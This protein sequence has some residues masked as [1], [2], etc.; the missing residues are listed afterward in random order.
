MWEGLLMKFMEGSKL[1]DMLIQT[2]D[3]KLVERTNKDKFW[4]DGGNGSGANKLG[5]MLM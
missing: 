4:G 1:A 2:G 5:I 3:A